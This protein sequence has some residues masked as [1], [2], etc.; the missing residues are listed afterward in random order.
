MKPIDDAILYDIQ[1]HEFS[2]DLPFYK[3][4]LEGNRGEVLEVGAGTGRLTLPLLE[5]GH[6]ISALELDSLALERLCQKAEAQFDDKTLKKLTVI[7]G[8][9]LDF[10]MPDTYSRIFLPFN[11]LILLTT[12][13][14]LLQCLQSLGN[15]LK[16]RGRGLIALFNPRLEHLVTPAVRNHIFTRDHKGIRLSEYESNSYDRATQILDVT[17]HYQMEKAGKQTNFDKQLRLR[18]IFPRELQLLMKLAGLEITNLWGDFDG[19]PFTT[20]SNHMLMEFR[21]GN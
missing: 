17:Y 7:H 5:A 12:D 18:V 1:N 9:V 16:K 21:K 4:W 6:R 19:R 15:A 20:T 14:E 13:D 3:G 8:N 10:D 2:A 11:F